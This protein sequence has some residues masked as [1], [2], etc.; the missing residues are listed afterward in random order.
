MKRTIAPYRKLWFTLPLLALS[1]AASFFLTFA[2]TGVESAGSKG[3]KIKHHRVVFQ[4]NSDDP[5]TM[6]HAIAN[7]LNAT[8]YY[9]E[10][11]ET[12]DVE[13]VAYGPGIHMFRADTS[14]V[15]DL[16]NVM[17]ASSPAIKFTVCGNTRQ[18]MELKEGRALP[19]VEGAT[20]VPS[21][22]VRVIELQEA[23]WSYA[24][25]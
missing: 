6:K 13:I 3:T 1:L 12:I 8:K 21:G 17:R 14:P 5:A 16:L 23:G 11:N 19:L 7:S 9:Q 15:K 18:I 10:R 2:L 24:R 4:V 25:P 20:V 22:I